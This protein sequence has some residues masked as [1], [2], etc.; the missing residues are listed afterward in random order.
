M[1]IQEFE[2][3][4][5]MNLFFDPLTPYEEVEPGDLRLIYYTSAETA[6][7]I[8]K[9]EEIWF[10]NASV[11]N[12]YME[13]QHGFEL[14]QHA[15][16]S[17]AGKRFQ[18]FVNSKFPNALS[19][20]DEELM[21]RYYDLVLDTYLVCPSMYNDFED[22]NGRL[23]MWRAYGDVAFVIN[24]TPFKE[25]P[26]ELGVYST[27]AQYLTESRVVDRMENL[28]KLFKEK[29]D[30]LDSLG[31]DSFCNVVHHVMSLFVV[32]AKRPEF[33]EEKEWRIFFRPSYRS[34]SVME[35]KIVA[36][37]GDVQKVWALPLRHSPDEGLHRADIPSL[38]DHVIIGPVKHP[39]ICKEAIR[40]ML[41]DI[42]VNDAES[43]IKISPLSL[44]TDWRF[45]KWSS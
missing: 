31:E 38:L 27:P 40:K 23:S 34:S 14:L 9:N 41:S 19:R 26:Y 4:F 6:M 35:E 2:A 18:E 22:A 29:S 36:I 11:M 24:N 15:F 39:E 32:A 45:A 16:S 42:D 13:I 37:D 44:R 5:F 8:L 30:E 43:K 7:N 21:V 17:D 10:R 28:V 33:S 25:A 12:D 1:N 20:I 3:A